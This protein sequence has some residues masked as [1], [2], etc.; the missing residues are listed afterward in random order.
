MKTL[1]ALLFA[2]LSVASFAHEIDGTPMLKGTVKADV[3]VNSIKTTCK[4]KVKK[5]KNSMT[6]DSFG[7]PA[8]TAEVSVSL[9]GG[10]LG[11]PRKVKFDKDLTLTNLFATG[12]RDLE[13]AGEGITLMIDADGGLV[14]AIIPYNSTKV[15]CEF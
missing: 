4:V 9:D 6:E 5:V 2:S 1:F 11:S 8:Y 13:Y 10:D 15:V 3:R 14:K 12:V 7:N